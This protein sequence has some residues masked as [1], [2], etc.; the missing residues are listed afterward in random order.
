[1]CDQTNNCENKHIKSKVHQ[2]T[3]E[4]HERCTEEEEVDFDHFVRDKHSK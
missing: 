2:D 4:D 3:T 1:M